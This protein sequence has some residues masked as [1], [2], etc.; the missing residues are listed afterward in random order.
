MKPSIQ[1]IT[2]S[3]VFVGTIAV[4]GVAIERQR[5][6]LTP[7][8]LSGAPIAVKPGAATLCVARQFVD[9]HELRLAVTRD[10][11]LTGRIDLAAFSADLSGFTPKRYETDAAVQGRYQASPDWVRITIL[12]EAAPASG[13]DLEPV[14]GPARCSVRTRVDDL[15]FDY[16][17]PKTLMADWPK[18]HANALRRVGEWAKDSSCR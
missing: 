3:V 1:I 13:L 9:P 4:L 7:D 6:P 5:A 15:R 11:P 8:L 17:F 10:E 2:V 12:P 18:L 16:S 14:C